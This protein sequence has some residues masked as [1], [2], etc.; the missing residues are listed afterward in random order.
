MG[1]LVF[2]L[3]LHAAKGLRIQRR[4]GGAGID[5][6]AP[7]HHGLF[8]RLNFDARGVFPPKRQLI[9]AQGDLTGVAKRCNFSDRDN[10]TGGQSHVH[11]AALDG[12]NPAADG[13]DPTGLAG[14]Q[15]I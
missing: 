8:D 7:A 2:M 15:K 9:A 6:P 12:R 3:L 5:G 13:R 11:Q 4:L 1:F 10:G 14:L